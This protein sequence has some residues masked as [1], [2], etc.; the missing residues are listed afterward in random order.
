MLYKVVLTF[1]SVDETPVSD[2]SMKATEQYFR[3]VLFSRLVLILIIDLTLS[4]FRLFLV[5]KT[6]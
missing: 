4:I 5:R 1:K 6:F 3:I 2:Y